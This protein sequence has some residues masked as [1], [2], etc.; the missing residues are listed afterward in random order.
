MSQPNPDPR[1]AESLLEGNELI[2]GEFGITAEIPS[3]QL[4]QEWQEKRLSLCYG[5]YRMV[6]PPAVRKLQEELCE[7]TGMSHA[8][9]YTSSEAALDEWLRTHF[10]IPPQHPILLLAEAEE[11]EL[12][13]ITGL[14]KAHQLPWM[15]L[16]SQVPARVPPCSAIVVLRQ[17][18]EVDRMLTILWHSLSVS[19]PLLVWSTEVPGKLARKLREATWICDLKGE[20]GGGVLMPE[21]STFFEEFL[22]RR[23]R[24][25]PLLSP[26]VV[27]RAPGVPDESKEQTSAFNEV[28]KWFVKQEQAGVALLY[29]SGMSACAAVFDAL[30]QLR[31]RHAVVIG[32]LYT[33][34]HTLLTTPRFRP[35]GTRV[36]FLDVSEQDQIAE[37]LT[38]ETAFVFLESITNP[39]GEVPDLPFIAANASLRQVPLVVDN[40]LATPFN[41]APLQFGADVVIESTAKYLSGQNDHRGGAVVLN[42]P[43]LAVALYQD[44]QARNLRMSDEEATVLQE[45]LRDFPDRMRRFNRNGRILRDFLQRHPKVAEVFSPHEQRGTDPESGFL[46]GVAG[47]VSFRLVSD[48][49]EGVQRLYDSDL[50]PIGKGP[51]LGSNRTILCPY[52]LLAHYHAPEELVEQLCATRYLIRVAAGCEEDFTVVL[53]ALGHGL[54]AV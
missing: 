39:L 28:E 12:E 52:P 10:I 14:F 35:E 13:R 43:T 51:T 24:R 11:P 22:E 19:L 20:S 36:D 21:S 15:Q 17:S 34:T 53:R 9:C 50:R 18:P 32:G 8:L 4:I 33:D 6:D 49:A 27:R 5:Y 7:A 45:R 46:A 16:P 48:S 54:D 25:G 31:P 38:E 40:T 44:Q 47:V 26:R 29:P 30:L 2:D 3:F 41:L 1:L 23:K 42:D 37:V